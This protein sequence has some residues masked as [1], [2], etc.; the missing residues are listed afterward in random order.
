MSLPTNNTGGKE[1]PN[2]GFISTLMLGERL[3][4]NA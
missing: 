1:E 4:N 3:E 2:I